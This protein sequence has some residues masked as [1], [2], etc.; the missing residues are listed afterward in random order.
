MSENQLLSD[1]G[2]EIRAWRRPVP[3]YVRNKPLPSAHMLEMI[4]QSIIREC[5]ETIY[6]TERMQA[7][8]AAGL[9]KTNEYRW[10]ELDLYRSQDRLSDAQRAETRAKSL[11]AREAR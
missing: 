9:A 7:M 10:M 4:R 8:Q 6:L 5:D 1:D 3:I 2:R 11:K